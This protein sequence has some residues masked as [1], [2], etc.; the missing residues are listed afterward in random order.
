M[1]IHPIILWTDALLYLLVIAVSAAIMAARHSEHW[2][3]AWHRVLVNRMALVA[4][5]IL[6]LYI[7][8]GLLDSIHFE[9]QPKNETPIT[10][11]V[12]D[13]IVSPLRDHTEKTY[14]APFAT[15]LYTADLFIQADGSIKSD[16]APLVYRYHILGTD[17]IGE[18]V[19]Y[20]ALKSIRTGLIIGTL[21]TLV[22][23]PFAVI[24]GMLAGYFRGWLDD[25]IQY[26]YTTLSSI[27]DILLIV[28]AILAW[29]IFMTNH[30]D[31]LPNLLQRADIR[32]LTLCVILGITSWT[33]LC[34]LLRGE[35]LKLR[36]MDYVQ[37]ARALGT[38]NSNILI[39][40]ILPNLMH[41]I[42]ISVVIDFSGLV[43]AEAVLTYVGVGVD[44]T[45]MS[46]GNMIF[47]ARQELARDP[48]VWWPLVA[49]F[50]FMFPL[51]ISANLFAD[52]VRDA[53]D[54]R[55][56]I[57]LPLLGGKR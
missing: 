4:M 51:V 27:P 50:I 16:Y 49:A 31:I 13:Y 36:E 54:P 43:L 14:S 44:P 57:S 46:W 23:L 21:T 28:A 32:L 26:V 45:T 33:G 41:I 22:M 12:F 30:P 24:F 29:Q 48:I 5:S 55:L 25:L 1:I 42:L 53:L 15:H 39:Q 37:A 10:E 56:K 3:A 52:A 6:L 17:K 47:A 18:D 7:V 38:K 19:L 35:T 34:R 8:V 40:H 11:S 9:F 2:R 20:E